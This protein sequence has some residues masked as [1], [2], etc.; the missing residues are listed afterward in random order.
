MSEYGFYNY[1]IQTKRK[2]F[3]IKQF[4]FKKVWI[5]IIQSDKFRFDKLST[6]CMLKKLTFL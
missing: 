1:K 5:E 4:N 2:K 6:V 3:E